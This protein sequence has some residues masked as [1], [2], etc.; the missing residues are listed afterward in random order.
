MAVRGRNV[1]HK[2]AT[3]QCLGLCEPCAIRSVQWAHCKPEQR[4]LFYQ[5]GNVTRR[6]GMLQGI[7]EI[8]PA[9]QCWQSPALST[10]Q[11][12][13]R[14][15][16]STQLLLGMTYLTERE[17]SPGALSLSLM[18]KAPS[19]LCLPN[20]SSAFARGIFPKN[21][22]CGEEKKVIGKVKNFNPFMEEPETPQLWKQD[23]VYALP[24]SAQWKMHFV[25][26]SISCL[27]QIRC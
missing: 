19:C 13:S 15:L 9:P 3:R 25:S 5:R 7:C 14:S 1:V 8:I 2:E 6:T 20:I 16:I 4:C 18:R 26:K 23:L 21:H 12:S 17:K 10:V 22:L 11:R 24:H 27:L